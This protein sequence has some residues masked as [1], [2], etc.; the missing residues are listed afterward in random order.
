[1][2]SSKEIA[3]GAVGSRAVALEIYTIRQA[4][5]DTRRTMQTEV[6]V[7]F[8]SLYAMFT[9]ETHE[10]NI[11]DAM[12]EILVMGDIQML[13]KSGIAQAVVVLDALA[14]GA[15][16][17]AVQL[18]HTFFVGI[19]TW[20]RFIL[21]QGVVLRL[22]A[23]VEFTSKPNIPV[24]TLTPKIRIHLVARATIDTIQVTSQGA[25]VCAGHGRLILTELASIVCLVITSSITITVALLLTAIEFLHACTTMKTSLGPTKL[26]ADFTVRP[27][28]AWPWNLFDEIDGQTLIKI[29]GP[30]NVPLG[31]SQ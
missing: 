18:T 19:Y 28:E 17:S 16:V 4:F 25:S 9:L 15:I 1:M 23:N 10:I 24:R 22:V 21:A 31:H 30:L 2:F 12:L 27:V 26:G 8:T 13:S 3:D 11:A 6:V 20:G 14:A 7:V 29:Q 5:L